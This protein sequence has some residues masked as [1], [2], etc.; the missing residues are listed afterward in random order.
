MKRFFAVLTV[1]FFGLPFL[2][3]GFLS[4]DFLSADEGMWLFSDPPLERIEKEYG[5]KLDGAFLNHL[6]KSSVRFSNGGSGSFVSSDGLVMT[7][8]HVALSFVKKLSTPEKNY[9]E[10]GFY[11]PT[12]ADE[13][14]CADIE[15][16]TLV[17]ILDVTERVRRAESGGDSAEE[18]RRARQREISL[19]ESE[20]LKE[21]G[22][23]SEVMSFYRGGLY[24]LYRYKKFSDVRLVFA[25]EE[26]VGYFGGETDNFEYPRW[27]L[28]VSFFRVYENGSP[29][30]PSDR[31]AWSASGAADGELVFVS[32][33]PGRTD[34]LDTV[35]HLEFL[36]DRYYP[37]F[38]NHVRRDEI[39]LQLFSERGA[40]EARRAQSDYF[41][42]RNTRKGRSGILLGLQTPELLDAKRAEE[43]ALRAAF[44]EKA[45]GEPD[46]WG[47]IDRALAVWRDNLIPYEMLENDQAFR[48]SLYKIAKMIVRVA[49]ES[50]KPDDRRLPEYRSTALE[51]LRRAVRTPTPIDAEIETVRLA[52]SLGLLL[53]TLG[54]KERGSADAPGWNLLEGRSP[55][56]R[57][58]ELV[59]GTKL[60]D[61]SEREK[62]LAGGL[63]AV[64]ASDD[65]MIRLA[66]RVDPLAREIR[67]IQENEVSEPMQAAYTRLARLRL[68]TMRGDCYPDATF[69]LRLA[70]GKVAGYTASDGTTIPPWTTIDGAYKRAESHD[71]AGAFALSPKWFER[72]ADVDESTPLNLI[73]TND[74]IG[75]NSGSPL[76]NTKGEVVGLIFDGNVDSLSL[77]FLFSEKTARAVS[78]HSSGI[79]EA[80]RKIYRTDALCDELGK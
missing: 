56:E 7:N 65:P 6:Q 2:A 8:H 48:S 1:L 46:P 29:Y 54:D 20:S 19:I 74:I 70:Y 80:L 18:K 31:L 63:E 41:G 72:R 50:Q 59:A 38:L 73:S 25:P 47:E 52:D 39:A 75:G 53:E 78:V 77:N 49:A 32:G 15:L 58:A 44:A 27:N 5:F 69:T 14:P 42:V 79:R 34:R 36:R 67:T 3:V 30:R 45:A 55:K 28:D 16:I 17:D 12:R 33:H 71:C 40:D 43:S 51:S 13:L 66:L 57:A 23:F 4:T 26:S 60:F 11:A 37:F 10:T 24:H 21:T 68:E 62:L 9:V 64:R 22:L 61:V 35:A 76:V